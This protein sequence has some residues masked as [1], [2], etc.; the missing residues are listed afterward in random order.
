MAEEP[1][2]SAQG[3]C[4]LSCLY[5]CQC[6]PAGWQHAHPQHD[7]EKSPSVACGLSRALLTRCRVQDDCSFRDQKGLTSCGS[8]LPSSFDFGAG[9][10]MYGG[11]LLGPAVIVV[12]LKHTGK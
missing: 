9:V 4:V 3:P 6:G 1:P 11:G 2:K 10:I 7:Q 8:V 5:E 12:Y